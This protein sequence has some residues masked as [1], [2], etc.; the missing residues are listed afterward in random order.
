MSRRSARA[1]RQKVMLPLLAI[2]ILSAVVIGVLAYFSIEAQLVR[3]LR[4]RAVQI[5]DTVSVGSESLDEIKELQHSVL[6]MSVSPDTSLIIVVDQNQR[7]IAASRSNLI[8]RQANGDPKLDSAADISRVIT[9]K[10]RFPRAY[11]RH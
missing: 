6:A 10:E 7:I 2:G 4:Y 8:D 5:I 9:T 11:Q 3:Q 1:L